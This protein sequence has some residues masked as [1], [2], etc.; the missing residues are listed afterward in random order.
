MYGGRQRERWTSFRATAQRG[1]ISLYVYIAERV[2][3]AFVLC[4]VVGKCEDFGD[5]RTFAFMADYRRAKRLVKSDNLIKR[6]LVYRESLVSK[7][8]GDLDD[9]FVFCVA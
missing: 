5:L 1:G 2:V 4:S 3:A 9:W 7:L 8:F 6:I